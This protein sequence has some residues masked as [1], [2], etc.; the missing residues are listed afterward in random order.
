[1]ARHPLGGR[2]GGG[3]FREREADGLGCSLLSE[4][5]ILRFCTLNAGVRIT[6]SLVT[7]GLM[8]PTVINCQ[9]K[10]RSDKSDPC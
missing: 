2:V 9:R 4:G 3:R 7:Q 6:S 5:D 1:M 10:A 8:H